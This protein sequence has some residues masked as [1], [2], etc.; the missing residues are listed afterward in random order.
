MS[1]TVTYTAPL[2]QLSLPLTLA[3]VPSLMSEAKRVVR[4]TERELA[5]LSQS[6]QGTQPMSSFM[7]KRRN[8]S[9]FNSC[10]VIVPMI[11]MCE[12]RIPLY[13]GLGL[14]APGCH[15]SWWLGVAALLLPRGFVGKLYGSCHLFSKEPG[16]GYA[17]SRSNSLF[18]HGFLLHM[19]AVD[20]VNTIIAPDLVGKVGCRSGGICVDLVILEQIT[21]SPWNNFLFMMYYGLVIEDFETKINLLKLAHFA[22]IISRQYSEKEAS[23]GYLGRFLYVV[24]DRFLVVPLCVDYSPKRHMRWIS[25]GIQLRVKLAILIYPLKDNHI[26]LKAEALDDSHEARNSAAVVNELSKEITKI[27]VSHPVNAKRAAEGKNIA[28]V[29]LLRGCGIRIEARI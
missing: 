9:C 25:F 22:V 20:N 26:L 16:D 28:N 19:Q 27:L 21:S 15:V 11:S 3:T 12:I 6:K 2:K 1:D 4:P 23:V 29:V 24:L 17:I 7:T 18:L 10:N 5:S 8:Q 14:L 13:F